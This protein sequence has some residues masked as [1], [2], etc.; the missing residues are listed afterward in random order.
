MKPVYWIAGGAVLV[1]L[2]YAA[3]KRAGGA[4]GV[5][6]VAGSAM[7]EAADGF[8]SEAVFT[9][10]EKIGIPRTDANECARAKAEG[11]TW[12]ASFVCPAAD[13]LK[14]VFN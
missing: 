14:Y 13:F 1:A 5:G 11:R 7:I 10:G 12:D 9:I 4:A 6:T 2:A 3:V 8:V